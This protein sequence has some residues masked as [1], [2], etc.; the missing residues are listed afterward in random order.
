[1]ATIQG[2]K[3]QSCSYLVKTSINIPLI[4]RNQ[5][6]YRL[7]HVRCIVLHYKQKGQKIEIDPIFLIM[8][9]KCS[10]WE[11][12][13]LQKRIVIFVISAMVCYYGNK[14]PTVKSY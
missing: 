10:S 14:A 1:M 12:N 3:F 9:S 6:K 2:V 13:N 5:K 7:T 8:V 4:I 11:N